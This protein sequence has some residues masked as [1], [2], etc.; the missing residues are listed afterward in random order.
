M[1]AIAASSSGP[2]ASSVTFEPLPAASI[3]TPMMLLALMRR[4]LR[5]MC[6]SHWYF[7]ASCVSFADARA[8]SPSLLTISTS[9]CCMERLE[10]QRAV[11]RA[12]K[13]LLDQR[14]H[15]AIAVRERADQHRQAGAG[16]AVDARR[17][18]QLDREV[19]R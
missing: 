4:P 7:A 5:A 19:G 11:A 8:C 3:I 2:S 1:A 14:R 15:V 10:V 16:D 17:I 13:R 6:T 18:E 9:R 12:G